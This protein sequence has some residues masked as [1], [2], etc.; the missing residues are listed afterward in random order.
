MWLKGETEKSKGEEVF[1]SGYLLASL[2]RIERKEFRPGVGEIVNIFGFVG[3]IVFIATTQL[4]FC[5]T[6]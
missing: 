6:R 4:C 1:W 2:L 5:S 3:R